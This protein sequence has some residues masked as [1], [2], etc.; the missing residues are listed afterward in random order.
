M[1][2]LLVRQP[3]TKEARYAHLLC[4]AVDRLDPARSPRYMPKQLRHWGRATASELRELEA[5]LAELANEMAELRARF[6]EFSGSSLIS[7]TGETL[8]FCL[9]SGTW[10]RQSRR[11]KRASISRRG[12]CGDGQGAVSRSWI[13][14]S[15]VQGDL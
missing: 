2:A 7:S 14:P 9:L 11:P 3:G 4:G 5:R 12:H 15:F 1:A 10:P 13:L 8:Q 6:A